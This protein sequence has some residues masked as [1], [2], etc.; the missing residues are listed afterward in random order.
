MFHH[1]DTA[2]SA[3][4]PAEHLAQGH[5]SALADS[6]V[7]MRADCCPGRPIFK[8]V[9]PPTKARPR[10][11]DLWLCGHHYRVSQAALKSAGAHVQPLAGSTD[12]AVGAGLPAGVAH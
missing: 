7:P 2:T 12:Y 9:M 4:A 1:H 10:P 5:T 8:V 11:A 6:S 3:G